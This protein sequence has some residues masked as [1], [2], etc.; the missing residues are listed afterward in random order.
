[1]KA[2]A[3]L[4]KIALVLGTGILGTFI[5]GGIHKL[6][7]PERNLDAAFAVLNTAFYGFIFGILIGIAF[8]FFLD[9]KYISRL[10][11]SI[12]IVLLVLL[13]MLLI[14]AFFF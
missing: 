11:S 7:R 5:A 9:E 3:V 12:L 1:M 8:V 14:L 6:F 4:V 10:A 13:L 2:K